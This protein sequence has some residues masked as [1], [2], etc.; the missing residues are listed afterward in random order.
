MAAGGVKAI[1][2]YVTTTYIIPL[3]VPIV[4]VAI[5]YASGMPWFYIWLGAL[6]AFAFVST[7]LLRFS[8]WRYRQEV[9]EKLGFNIVRLRKKLNN[10]GCVESLGL[11]F[12]LR[13]NALFPVEFE[14]QFLH[15]EIDKKFPPKKEYPT[16]QVIIPAGGIGWFDDHSIELSDPPRDRSVEGRIQFVVRYGRIGNLKHEF[17]KNLQVFVGFDVKGDAKV[18]NWNELRI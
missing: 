3:G 17:E 11:G 4:T 7:S 1:A 8:E 15:T 5:G 14:L 18:A 2:F 12:Q 9:K 6:A 16:K 13:N 10:L